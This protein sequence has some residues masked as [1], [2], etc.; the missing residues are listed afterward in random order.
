MADD[1]AREQ[2]FEAIR[3]LRSRIAQ[4]RATT[5]DEAMR[6]KIDEVSRRLD[7]AAAALQTAKIGESTRLQMTDE[8]LALARQTIELIQRAR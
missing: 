8:H 3:R 7:D 4:L 5:R 1:F 6:A 2:R